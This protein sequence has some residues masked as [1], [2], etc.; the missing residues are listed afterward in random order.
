DGN[1][2]P[3]PEGYDPAAYAQG[4]Y[5]EDGN[6]YPYTA[7]QLA[8]WAEQQG[9]D[10]EQAAAWAQQQVY[11]PNAYAAGYDSNAAPQEPLVPEAPVDALTQ[12]N[13]FDSPEIAPEAVPEQEL[14]VAPES[15]FDAPSEPAYGATAEPD[16]QSLPE[17]EAAPE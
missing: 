5:A 7:E 1:W 9:Y 8:Q 2:Y 3:Y 12:G 4:Y 6:W 16:L 13:G 14:E 10:P 17:L 11:D 15:L